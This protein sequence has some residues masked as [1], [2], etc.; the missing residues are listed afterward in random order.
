MKATPQW[1]TCPP[2]SGSQSLTGSAWELSY[3]PE[4]GGGAL[5]SRAASVLTSA[6]TS[7]V[8]C[9]Q[10]AAL[11]T[12]PGK[13]I[14]RTLDEAETELEPEPGPRP[15]PSPPLAVSERHGSGVSRRALFF[16]PNLPGPSGDH[17]LTANGLKDAN[18]SCY[19][20]LFCQ[21]VFGHSKHLLLFLYAIKAALE[22]NNH[23]IVV[24]YQGS[25]SG[26]ARAQTA[27]H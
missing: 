9:Y 26:P 16:L 18:S 13:F 27:C 10:R 17:E 6:V 3:R 20:F 11:R 23:W 25:G 8:T 21:S 7:A 1:R 24:C 15:S 4:P 19:L 5:L 2:P 14:R 22:M 12:D